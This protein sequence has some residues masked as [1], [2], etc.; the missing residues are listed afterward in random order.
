MNTH[1]CVANTA[2]DE[3]A[4]QCSHTRRP[5]CRRPIPY[6]VLNLLAHAHQLLLRDFFGAAI[7]LKEKSTSLLWRSIIEQDGEIHAARSNECG[8]KPLR[9]VRRHEDDTFLAGGDTVQCIEET[10]E[11]YGGLVPTLLLAAALIWLG[12]R[13]T[14]RRSF[15]R[16]C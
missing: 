15:V 8:V 4:L 14:R 6:Y 10:G 2:S 13:R 9:V 3:Q 7:E 12:L 1:Y 11:C 16:A 5:P